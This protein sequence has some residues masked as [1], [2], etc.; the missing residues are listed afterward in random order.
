MGDFYEPPRRG[1]VDRS[2]EAETGA[3]GFSA[4][5]ALGPR[6][7]GQ[8]TA[9]ERHAERLEKALAHL[10][11]RCRAHTQEPALCQEL[12]AGAWLEF[13]GLFLYGAAARD[14]G[15]RDD[16]VFTWRSLEE[17]RRRH[18]DDE[19]C[20]H[21]QL[22][23]CGSIQHVRDHPD[24]PPS[25]MGS[26]SDWLHDL[27]AD[28]VAREARGDTSLPSTLGSTRLKDQEFAARSALAV[29]TDHRTAGY[30]RGHAR[31]P[32][33]FPPKP[34][35]HR[36][37]IATPLYVETGLQPPPAEVASAVPLTTGWLT[38]WP[39]RCP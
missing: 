31:V 26:G 29:H 28:P 25:R 38:R 37:I 9:G 30:L 7:A 14:L 8:P 1:L 34:L 17:D 22:L 4:R 6:N 12:G 11:E 3:Q 2:L 33:N 20:G 32:C 16:G 39:R 15:L 23:L 19:F 5:L 13:C 36:L 27:A 21:I 24:H 18:R 35:R 10:R